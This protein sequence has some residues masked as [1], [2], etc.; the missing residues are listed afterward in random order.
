MGA[1]DRGVREPVEGIAGADLV[2]LAAPVRASID[3][4]HV[5]AP[6][7][8]PG[9]IVTDMGSTKAEIMAAAHSTLGPGKF[10][11]G[12]PMAGSHRSGIAVASA[13]LFEGAPYI[14][15]AEADTPSAIRESLWNLAVRL[16]ARPRWIEALDH[17]RLVARISHLPHVAACALVECADGCTLGS[18]AAMDL[19]ASGFRDTTRVAAGSAAMWTDICLTSRAGILEALDAYTVS[20]QRL[21]SRIAGGDEEALMQWFEAMR[22]A[23]RR[24]DTTESGE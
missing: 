6:A 11:G 7:L 20:L 8:K 24:L 5:I 1:F 13:D 2:V 4:L 3:L 16:G 19:A 23:R 9:A 18:S 21:R 17:D 12:H 15:S 14:L 10:V 22:S